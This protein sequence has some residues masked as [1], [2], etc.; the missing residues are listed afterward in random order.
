MQASAFGLGVD[1]FCRPLREVGLLVMPDAG[2]DAT[3]CVESICEVSQAAGV[4][5]LRVLGMAVRV[6]INPPSVAH[7]VQVMN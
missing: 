4:L 3:R 6:F 2:L 5:W 1:M 7:R